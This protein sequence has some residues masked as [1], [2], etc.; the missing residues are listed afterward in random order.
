MKKL[1]IPLAALI[2][3][4]EGALSHAPARGQARF[5]SAA[6]RLVSQQLL[7]PM[8][9]ADSERSIFSRVPLPSDRRARILEGEHVDAR[10][11][12][13]VRFAIDLYFGRGDDHPNTNVMSGCVYP[14]RGEVFVESRAGSGEF[15]PAWSYLYGPEI[16]AGVCHEA[17]S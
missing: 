11:R 1:S 8:R 14:G 17:G 3:L 13:F 2:L 6:A 10:G 16:V 5:D 15:V 9:E 7:E 12:T 4:A